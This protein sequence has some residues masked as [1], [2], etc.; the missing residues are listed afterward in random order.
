MDMINVADMNHGRENHGC[1]YLFNVLRLFI[2]GLLISILSG[3][4]TNILWP[5]SLTHS[6]QVHPD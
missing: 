6:N 2:E 5:N 4:S 3:Y 1:L